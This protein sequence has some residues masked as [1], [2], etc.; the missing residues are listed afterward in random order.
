MIYYS[1]LLIA[2]FI[3]MAL[4]PIFKSLASTMHVMDVPSERKVHQIPMPKTGGFAMALGA[5]VPLFLWATLDK[6]GQSIMIGAGI[7]VFFGFIDDIKELGYKSKFAGQLSASLVIVLYG[8]IRI[9]CLG[10]LLPDDFLLPE[11]LALPLTIFFVVGVTNAINLADGLDG[12]AGG[13]SLLSFICIAY[14]ALLGENTPIALFALAMAGAIFGFLRFN[15]YP[16]TVFMG[17]TGSQLIGF[18]AGALSV[19]L[20]QGNTPLSPMLPLL[21]LGFPILDTITVM[22]ERLAEGS[23][24]FVADKKHFHHKLMELGLYHTEAV[25]VIYILQAFLVTS[26][27][28]FRFHSDWL[29]LLL[30]V[31]FSCTTI[32]TFW[33]LGRTGWSFQRYG[34]FDVFVKGR[35]K[36][37]KEKNVFIKI[38]FGIFKIGIPILFFFSCVVPANIPGY[39]SL[40]AAG[41]AILLLLFWFFRAELLPTMLRISLYLLIPF[42]IYLAEIDVSIWVN[43]L[44]NQLLIALY[45][46]MVI[47]MMLTLRLTRRQ[48]GFK[49][50]PMDFLILF[51]AMIVPNLPDQYIQSY[52]LGGV[53]AKIIVL[54]FSYEV[55]IGELRGRLNWVVFSTIA[56]LVALSVKGVVS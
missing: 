11:Y 33:L 53:A 48:K 18:V 10:M 54:F 51:I 56:A 44:M 28:I 43:D 45:A 49:S 2:M 12:L 32:I 9:K 40:F 42:V 19:S 4:V 36:I 6:A 15:T 26:A 17:D 24:P 30:Y 38:A 31:T 3:T 25:F 13:I 52:H 14:M 8:G 7:I 21:L 50:S 22:L 55:L 27:F 23:S 41:M 5:M 29:L 34:F 46:S 39:F 35:L 37:L 20:T 16:A 47:F 1:T